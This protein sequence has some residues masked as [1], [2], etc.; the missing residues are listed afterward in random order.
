[1][2]DGMPI[3]VKVTEIDE[4][5]PTVRTIRFDHSF[6]IRPG[7]FCMVWVPGVDEVPM[8]FSSANS[9][10]V[11]RVGE[12]TEALTKLKVGDSFGIRGPF[13]NGFTPR[14]RVLAIGGGVGVVPLYPLA[15]EGSVKT[16]ILGARTERELVFAHQLED[17]TDLRIATDDGSEG[18]HGFVTGVLDQDIDLVSYDTICVCGPEMMMKG[19]LDRL[20]GAGIAS[21]GQFSLHRYMKCGIGVCGSCSIDPEGL[22]VCRDGPVFTGDRLLNSEFG[23][24]ARDASGQKK[25]P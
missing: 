15:K 18:Y 20:D 8:G 10:T 13:G 12:A 5:T 17:I 25:R 7:Q 21:H 23:T 6:T 19:I 16:F 9:I 11:Q 14:G 22:R 1:M 3:T 4:E 2:H 24:Y